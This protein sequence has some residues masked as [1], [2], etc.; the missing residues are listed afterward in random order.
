MAEAEHV[1][2]H[3]ETLDF[4]ADCAEF[5][6]LPGFTH[7]LA[8]GTYQLLEEKQER[9]G[10]CYLRTLHRGS[11]VGGEPSGGT[12]AAS[13]DMPG[14]FDLKWRPTAYSGQ[15]A[16]LGAALAD[17]TVRCLEA[18]AASDDMPAEKAQA[19]LRQRSEVAACSS[20]MCLSLDWQVA[21]GSEQARIAVS[22]ST[23]TLS[24]IQTHSGFEP[25][26]ENIIF[27]GAD[28]C[29]FKAY[30]IRS[31]PSAPVFADRR[32]HKA[33]ICTVS[34]HPT[35]RHVVATGSY[36]EYVRLWDMRNTSKP[37]ILSQLNTS[38][39]NWRLRW[40]PHDPQLLL[41]A[42]IAE[43]HYDATGALVARPAHMS[44]THHTLPL[45]PS[46]DENGVILKAL[47]FEFIYRTCNRYNGF[48]VLR[49]A[50]DF[51]DLSV[52]AMYQ[53]PNK[54]IAYGAD[55][56]Q[57]GPCRTADASDTGGS[58]GRADKGR[59]LAATCSFYDR[60]HTLV[61]LRTE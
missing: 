7:L 60:L 4:N 12:H 29:Y 58:K 1:T 21:A 35:Q 51:R 2:I 3:S 19:Q 5:C 49:A 52:V 11:G 17:G 15:G 24:L 56:W 61:W 22:N 48:G 34:P 10:R 26:Q 32:T 55:W 27:S 53:S 45:P 18:V 9:V 38:G 31:D 37:F 25:L 44:Y 54:Y 42:C 33:G 16:V 36:D 39:G 43:T 50:G 14:I 47:M 23:G 30:D 20:G 28:D 13:L 8:L 40:H 57:E 41:A 46:G 59:A 6:P